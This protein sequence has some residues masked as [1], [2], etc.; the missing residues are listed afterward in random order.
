MSETT[1]TNSEALTKAINDVEYLVTDC[2]TAN[3]QLSDRIDELTAKVRSLNDTIN[4]LD[5]ELIEKNQEIKE[6]EDTIDS[7]LTSKYDVAK[8]MFNFVYSGSKE[9]ELKYWVEACHALSMEA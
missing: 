2:I 4:S 8:A 7:D 9:D 3:E 1:P 5:E 6:L